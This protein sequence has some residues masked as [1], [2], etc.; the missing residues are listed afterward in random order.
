MY[1][2][3][4]GGQQN[5]YKYDVSLELV[6]ECILYKPVP[7]SMT[8]NQGVNLSGT[9]YIS[10]TC[11]TGYHGNWQTDTHI[12]TLYLQG[13]TE[14]RT[15]SCQLSTSYRNARQGIVIGDLCLQQFHLYIL[16]NT[17]QSN[18]KTLL[19]IITEPGIY[20]WAEVCIN[21]KVII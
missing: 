8:Y 5:S 16:T 3:V 12:T 4:S 2:P 9:V 7:G 6:M 15:K 1:I 19:T 21:L 18:Q 13:R 11:I 17:T 20:P 14:S 10:Y